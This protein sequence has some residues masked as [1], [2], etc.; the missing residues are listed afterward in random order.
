MCTPPPKLKLVREIGEHKWSVGLQH[1]FEQES[2]PSGHRIIVCKHYNYNSFE[3]TEYDSYYEYSLE[4]TS[5]RYCVFRVLK[6]KYPDNRPD[7]L[8]YRQLWRKRTETP[9]L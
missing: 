5:S 8:L 1:L 9:K 7:K 3:D 2:Y 4:T 6:E